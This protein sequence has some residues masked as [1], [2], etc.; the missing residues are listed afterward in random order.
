MIALK[1]RRLS[2]IEAASVPVVASTA[3]QMV[4]DHGQVSNDKR[5]LVHGGAGNVGAYAIQFAKRAGA[6]VLAT[7]FDRD[8]DYIRSLGADRPID[9]QADR[10]ERNLDGL[11]VVIDT[12]G[13][14]LLDRSFEFLKPGGVLVSS[15]AMPDQEKAARHR[16]RGVFFLVKVTSEGLSRIADLLDSGQLTAHVGEVLPLAEA[17]RAHQMLAGKPHRRGKI[18]LE[19]DA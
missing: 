19:V 14:E 17:G 5:V 4:F 16:V 15:V 1:P 6:Q 7:G 10:F 8:L 12:I 2:Y 11:D 9:V 13:G 3:W 18:I